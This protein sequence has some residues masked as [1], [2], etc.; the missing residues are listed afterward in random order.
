M[1]TDFVLDDRPQVATLC[2]VTIILESAMSAATTAAL[3]P[4]S[5]AAPHRGRIL[6]ILGLARLTVVLDTTIVNIALPSAQAVGV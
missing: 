2:N 5:T 6:A 1:I 3:E 4:N